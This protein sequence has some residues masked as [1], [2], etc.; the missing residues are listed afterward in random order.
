MPLEPAKSSFP[1]PRAD[2]RRRGFRPWR[3]AA[4]GLCVAGAVAGCSDGSDA[5]HAL[6][7]SRT[8]EP[9]GPGIEWHASVEERHGLSA[10][11]F[12][13]PAAA[14]K[15]GP[16]GELHWRAPAGWKEKAPAP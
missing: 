6:G 2:R 1:E 14:A 7:P 15:A 8:Y 4:S 11:D 13:P 10:S 5:V 12:A 16:A 3:L 9:A